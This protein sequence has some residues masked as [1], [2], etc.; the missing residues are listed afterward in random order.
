MEPSEAPKDG[1]NS[2][3]SKAGGQKSLIK[4]KSKESRFVSYKQTTSQALSII[5]SLIEFHFLSEFKPLTFQHNTFQVLLFM[6]RS[7]YDKRN[8]SQL[9]LKAYKLHCFFSGS[10]DGPAS[11]FLL[12][13]VLAFFD[14]GFCIAVLAEGPTS[15][16]MF[17]APFAFLALG[18]P[19][20]PLSVGLA[21]SFSSDRLSG[22]T[23]QKLAPRS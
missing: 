19:T 12:L 16:S 20:T 13:A 5:L 9:R 6:T 8:L 1:R 17:S 2:K 23:L 3:Q 14:L 11:S 7:K 15:S 10:L 21:R 18:L 4:F 22:S